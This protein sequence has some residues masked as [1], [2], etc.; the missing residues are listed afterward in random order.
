MGDFWSGTTAYDENEG[1]RKK[2]KAKKAAIQQDARNAQATSLVTGATPGNPGQIL[3]GKK[4]EQQGQLAGLNLAA[5]GYGQSLGETG[6][7]IQRVKEL[8]NA[9]TAQSGSD[10][11]SAAIMSMKA[12][13]AA[14]ANRNLRASGVKGGTAAG[15]VANIENAAN[16]NIAASLYGQQ[17]QSIADERSLAGNT[18]SGT[19][20]L[21]QGEKAAGTKSPDAPQA[22]SW[23][24]SV[25]CTELNRQGIMPNDLYLKDSKYGRELD[26]S[27]VEGYKFLVAPIVFL[28]KKS[29]IFTKLISIP[30]MKWAK[31]IAGEENSFIGYVAVYIGQ[32][33]CGLIGKVKKLGVKYVSFCNY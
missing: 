20:S 12:G 5:L 17:R 2:A 21:M 6:Q 22:A 30:A 9:R 13:Q 23:T 14:N 33:V 15:S 1:K 26:P 29:K 10:P 32:P 7:D 16:E 18:L 28:M 25:I 19:T 31:H 4:G 8:Q 3:S 27:I 24:D 11:V